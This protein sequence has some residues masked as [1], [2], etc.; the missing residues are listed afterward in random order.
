MAVVVKTTEEP[1]LGDFGEFATH[2]GTYPLLVGTG[3]FAGGAIWILTLG[4]RTNI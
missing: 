1:I 4:Q 3:M 2:V